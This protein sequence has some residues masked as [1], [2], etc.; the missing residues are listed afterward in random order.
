[1]KIIFILVL[2]LLFIYTIN[3][4][5]QFLLEE[6]STCEF[7]AFGLSKED[8]ITKCTEWKTVGGNGKMTGE[9]CNTT[10]CETKCDEC[11]NTTRCKFD[12]DNDI[13]T[14]S[15]FGIEKGEDTIEITNTKSL[16]DL[17][18]N[19]KKIEPK[20][21]T[22]FGLQSISINDNSNELDIKTAHPNLIDKHS[23]YLVFVIGKYSDN[24]Y[25]KT[26]NLII[27]T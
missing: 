8:C 17:R 11:T 25:Y 27:K 26:N 12:L 1:M 9:L 14:L 23:K 16:D 24:K 5:E 3:Y 21:N 10:D 19:F 13:N 20:V 4:Y 7:V 15:G 22:D 6:F 2:I 18:L